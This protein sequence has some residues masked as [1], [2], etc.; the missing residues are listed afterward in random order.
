MKST[1]AIFCVPGEVLVGTRSPKPLLD[2]F[3]AVIWSLVR[4]LQQS[5]DFPV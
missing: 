2:I 1:G 3:L 4:E 5:K